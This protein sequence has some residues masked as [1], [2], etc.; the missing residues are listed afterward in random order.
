MKTELKPKRTG[1]YHHKGNVRHG[2][3]KDNRELFNIWQ[4]MRTRCENPNRENYKRYGARGITVC[5]E[6]NEAKNFVEWALNNGYKK[7]L[8]LD[9]IDNNKGYSPDNCRFVT[10]T[11]NSRNRRN[12]KFL[13]INGQTKCVSEWCEQ[14]SVSRYTVYYWIRKKGKEYSE[15]RLSEIA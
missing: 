6:W 8:Q 1:N 11:E 3:Y 7:G 2:L 12:T 13:T 14:K 15:Q 9:R 4:T 5:E 10:A